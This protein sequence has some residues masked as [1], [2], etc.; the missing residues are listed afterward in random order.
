MNIGDP[1]LTLY[2]RAELNLPTNFILVYGQSNCPALAF[3]REGTA[4]ITF[5][6]FMRKPY[7]YALT[8]LVQFV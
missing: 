2:N 4:D 5:D 3:N 7:N 6:E 1:I 8:E